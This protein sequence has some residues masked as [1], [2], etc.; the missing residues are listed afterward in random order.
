MGPGPAHSFGYEVL[1]AHPLG[2][3]VWYQPSFDSCNRTCRIWLG[4]PSR[5]PGPPESQ[6]Q[7]LGHPSQSGGACRLT[8]QDQANRLHD[9]ESPKGTCVHSLEPDPRF[10][11]PQGYSSKY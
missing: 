3:I 6:F 2:P 8:V 11:G 1:V 4:D 5:V 9:S 7:I 10:P